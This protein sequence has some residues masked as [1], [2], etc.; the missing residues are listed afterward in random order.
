MFYPIKN[1]EDLQKLDEAVSL[2]YQVKV[3]REQDNLGEQ[4]YH[5]NAEKLYKPLTDTIENVSEEV[6]KT[7]IENSNKNN[8]TLE[9]LNNKFPEIMND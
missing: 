5:Q 2:Q 9:N 4:N 8:Q 7:M 3:I 1:L 6:T